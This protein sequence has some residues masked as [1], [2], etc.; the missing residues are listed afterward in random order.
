MSVTASARSTARTPVAGVTA[1]IAVAVFVDPS[2]THVPLCP[3][4]SATGIYCPLCGGL[5]AL[6]ALSRGHVET[7]IRD[8]LLLV[9]AVAMLPVIAAYLRA[10][11]TD[12]HLTCRATLGRPTRGG[13]SRVHDRA[14]HAVGV[15]AATRVSRAAATRREPAQ[16]YPR[17]DQTRPNA[18]PQDGSEYS[19][20]QIIS[21]SC[22]ILGV[23]MLQ[24]VLAPLAIVFGALGV[25]AARN[26][27]TDTLVG[28]RSPAMRSASSTA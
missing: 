12:R 9:A 6:H 27:V 26:T 25:H 3:F 19:V 22:G 8:N 14:Q 18:R 11:G 10:T 15:G 4:H 7:A 16:G 28:W 13:R 23:V 20:S 17:P 1:A 2:T 24:I 5:R 21:V